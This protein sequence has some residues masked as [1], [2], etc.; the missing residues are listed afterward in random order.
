[1]SFLKSTGWSLVVVLLATSAAAAAGSSWQQLLADGDDD[2]K[3]Q[4]LLPAEECFRKALKEVER[5][6]HSDDELVACLE[7]LANVL[8]LEDKAEESMSLYRHSLRILEQ[9][10]GKDSSKVVPTLFA[11]GS[12]YESEGNPQPAMPLYRRAF[13]INEKNYGPYSPAVAS[14]LHRL[15]RATYK[16]GQPQ[17]AERHYKQSLRILMEQPGFTASH[18][19]EGLLSDYSDLL[20]KNDTSSR[21]LV[22]EFQREFVKDNT[23]AHIIEKD[24]PISAWQRQQSIQSSST[25]AAQNNEEQLV[26]RRGPGEPL[27]GS[28]LE[29]AYRIMND[30]FAKQHAYTQEEE[31]FQR[32]IAIDVSTLGPNHPTVANDLYGLVLLYISQHRYADAKPLL[33]RAL[34]IYHSVY[35]NDSL[36]VKTARTTLASVLNELGDTDKAAAL[37]REAA[38]QGQIV[39]KPTSMDTAQTLNELAFLYYS[40]GKLE[41]ACTVYQWALSSTEA[42]A[43]KDSPLVASCLNDYAKVLRA[44]GRTQEADQMQARAMTISATIPSL[45]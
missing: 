17:E 31:R 2:L 43:G 5:A 30:V 35:G 15:G 23:G 7:R 9:K 24:S 12:I 28:T 20:R 18:D 16:A 8:A 45:K 4:K 27:T 21:E 3:Q 39:L 29:P 19:L 34:T 13:P 25:R 32:M 11:L 10:Y 26:L 37:Y 40:E 1:M 14:S 33:E 44:L 41:D 36:L 38:C 22:S 6:P 42:A